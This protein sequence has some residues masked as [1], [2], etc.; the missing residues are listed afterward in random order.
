[1]ADK[2]IR[3][4]D[5]NNDNSSK[6]IRPDLSNSA[7]IR[8]QSTIGAAADKTLRGQQKEAARLSASFEKEYILD[9]VT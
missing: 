2:T 7:T 8:P 4:S 9:G 5:L 6:T 1:M 3:P